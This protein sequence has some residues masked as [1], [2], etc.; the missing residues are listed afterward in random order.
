MRFWKKYAEVQVRN[1]SMLCIGL[2]TT[3]EMVPPEYA[4]LEPREALTAFNR[5]VIEATHDLAAAYK[6]NLAFYEQHGIEGWQA[7]EDTLQMIPATCITIA[8]AKRGDIGNTSAGYAKTFFERYDCDALTVAP[9]MGRDS[10]APFLEYSDKMTFVLALTSNEGSHDFQ[11]KTVNG[12]PLY[13]DVIE[14]ARS[15]TAHNNVGFVVGATHVA[16][17]AEVRACFPDT[18][19]LIPGIGAQGGD[20]AAA[21]R[22]NAGG[23]AFINVSRGILQAPRQ[24][25]VALRE[26][27]RAAALSFMK[28]LRHGTADSTT[29]T[30][31]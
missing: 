25:G 23:V 27:I 10:V 26:T 14:T 16:E 8:D 20:A 4:G 21:V 13:M 11:R 29:I 28:D 17:L 7:F 9:Y 6:L 30:I 12:K 15:W 22:A 3:L 18:P 24:A 5:T 19:L 1:S 31:P 2:D